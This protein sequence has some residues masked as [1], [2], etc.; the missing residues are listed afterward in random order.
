MRNKLSLTIIISVFLMLS[1][2]KEKKMEKRLRWV[3]VSL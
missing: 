3:A 2:S 1:C